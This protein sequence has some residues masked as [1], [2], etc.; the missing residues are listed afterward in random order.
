MNFKTKRITG[1]SIYEQNSYNDDSCSFK[2]MNIEGVIESHL[3]SC[4]TATL[5]EKPSLLW[6]INTS[7][8]VVWV[9]FG[10]ST[11]VASTDSLVAFPILPSSKITYFSSVYSYIIVDKTGLCAY[12]LKDDVICIP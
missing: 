2:Y 8:S 4:I 1:R 12:K 5:I 3:G 10:D 11:V 9:T 6:L 7:S